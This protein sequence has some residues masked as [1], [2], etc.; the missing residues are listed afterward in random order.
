[1]LVDCLC[2]SSLHR[3][4]PTFPENLMSCPCFSVPVARPYSGYSLCPR[5]SRARDLNREIVCPSSPR[6]SQPQLELDPDV[7]AATAKPQ[8]KIAV[9]NLAESPDKTYKEENQ[10]AK[11]E[12]LSSQFALRHTDTKRRRDGLP[13]SDASHSAISNSHTQRR[14]KFEGDGAKTT[15]TSD[16]PLC[17]TAAWCCTV[18]PP[19][20]A[21]LPDRARHIWG[22]QLPGTLRA[23]LSRTRL[24]EYSCAVI[25]GQHQQR[26]QSVPQS[27]LAVGGGK[28]LVLEISNFTPLP[29]NHAAPP[30]VL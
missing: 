30:G 26:S 14:R 22:T 5:S 4:D 8:F 29:L 18:G 17:H 6:T 19:P 23:Q 13:M 9:Q 20:P 25:R 12:I 21:N 7:A 3:P 28:E 24:A 27:R 2:E 16:A 1:M 11:K 10:V 15:C